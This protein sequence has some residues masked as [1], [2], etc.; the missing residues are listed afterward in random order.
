MSVANEIAEIE[1]TMTEIR[2]NWNVMLQ[3]QVLIIIVVNVCRHSLIL[4]WLHLTCCRVGELMEVP[5]I[6]NLF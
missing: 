6:M 2:R 5:T 1:E 4:S 3:E